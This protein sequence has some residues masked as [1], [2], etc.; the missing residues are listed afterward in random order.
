MIVALELAVAVPAI[1]RRVRLVQ[2]SSCSKTERFSGRLVACVRLRRLGRSEAEIRAM[3][4]LS[5]PMVSRYCR[6][7]VQKE[8]AM[9]AVLRLDGTPWQR[10]VAR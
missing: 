9:A 7:S 4:G 6:L 1:F 3:V 2:G 10:S 5:L 8:N